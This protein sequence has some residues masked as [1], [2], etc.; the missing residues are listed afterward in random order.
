[1]RDG[2]IFFDPVQA[3]VLLAQG[4]GWLS[5][6]CD[7]Y[8]ARMEE[9]SRPA[10]AASHL[11]PF[12]P[13]P[14]Y[15][16]A[17]ALS[18]QAG[19]TYGPAFGETEQALFLLDMGQDD[20]AEAV[21]GLAPDRQVRLVRSGGRVRVE[22]AGQGVDL[23]G[24]E[25]RITLRR[26]GGHWLAA[27]EGL[28]VAQWP[29]QSA[30]LEPELRVLAGQVALV[31]AQSLAP[32]P[33]FIFFDTA[34]GDRIIPLPRERNPYRFEWGL[35]AIRV[36]AGFMMA[37]VLRDLLAVLRAEPT[38]LEDAALRSRLEDLDTA[39]SDVHARYLR[40]YLA[41]P[42]WRPGVGD[43]PETGPWD[44]NSFS[45]GVLA[46][47]VALLARLCPDQVN[48]TQVR[49]AIT[50]RASAYFLAAERLDFLNAS[51]G[52]LARW[53]VRRSANHGMIMMFAYLAA[54][55]LAGLEN[56]AGARFVHETGFAA[57]QVLYEDG[58]FCEGVHY[59]GFALAPCLPYFHLL[60]G[61]GSP[62][63]E[64]FETLLPQV[65]DWW[66]LTHDADGLVF[67]NF[68]D[69]VERESSRDRVSVGRFLKR[70]AAADLADAVDLDV[71]DA[72][73]PFARLGAHNPAPAQGLVS[74]VFE[75][76]RFAHA[77]FIDPQRGRQS[78]LFVIGS[79]M[80]ATHNRN[81]DAGGFAFYADQ[82]RI[83][84][85]R[86]DRQPLGNN[87]IVFL[88]EDSMPDLIQG[89]REYGGAVVAPAPCPADGLLLQSDVSQAGVRFKQAGPRKLTIRRTFLYRPGH[90][91]PLVVGT[92]LRGAKGL[93][94]ALA[95]NIHGEKGSDLPEFGSALLVGGDGWQVLAPTQIN[96]AQV[97]ASG[98]DKR[99]PLRFVSWFGAA[100]IP[101][102]ALAALLPWD[103]I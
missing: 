74:R 31:M 81:H 33:S 62:E 29:A 66:S 53:W 10:E 1:M 69:N 49:Q 51:K 17:F 35:R 14:A 21:I 5:D 18:I 23:P 27:A 9:L 73:T 82:W 83:G 64:A 36:N 75:R 88:D 19:E 103:E 55:R 40:A 46:F 24:P 43:Y 87:G 92:Q 79:R 91:C 38:L 12:M 90:P 56:S 76:N 42:R 67:A 63:L 99:R 7:L 20:Q 37:A 45:N 57:L 28:V 58:S 22:S 93:N 77:V 80:Q 52:R 68:G 50:A 47:S 15:E 32:V 78:G 39:W 26:H 54:T 30:T 96:G 25:V 86:S 70:Y 60:R 6:Y 48:Q 102:E 100:D 98:Q 8:Q 3:R 44:R 97:F 13:P 41:W 101:P 89:G 2:T 4:P 16:E 95:F 94:P 61:S 84:I 71:V 59:N 34:Q 72:F 85:D 65:Y 11:W